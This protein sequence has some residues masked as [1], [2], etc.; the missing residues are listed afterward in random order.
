MCPVGCENAY[1]VQNVSNVCLDYS[2]P[3][4]KMEWN[5]ME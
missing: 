3:I 1:T 4:V 5:K 2:S